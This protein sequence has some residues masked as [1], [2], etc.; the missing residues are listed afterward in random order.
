MSTIMTPNPT[1]VST[2]DSAIGALTIMV[3]N[4]FRHLPVVDGE[5]A[6]VGLLDIGKCL[7]DAIGR[8]ERA[9]K[10][11]GDSSSMD[12][13][14]QVAALRIPGN[15][16]AAVALQSLL[17][18]LM[19]QAAGGQAAVPTLRKLLRGKPSTIVW[20]STTI[21]ETARLMAESRHAAL[22]VDEGGSLV[23]IFGFK[24]M[25]TRVIACE[26][27]PD[28]TEVAEVMTSD[29]EFVSPDITVLEALQTMYD[30]KFLTVSI[31]RY[32]LC[33][34]QQDYLSH[35]SFLMS[36]CLYVRQMVL[37]LALLMLL[38]SFTDVVS[39]QG[40]Y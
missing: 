36:S 6:V 35:F 2:T 34:R 20:P 5:G 11:K 7:N 10:K 1:C 12:A 27:P 39:Y 32:F 13:V 26:L 21:R 25:M 29:P 17:G 3:E 30:N 16:N 37:L 14:N 38:N 4:H 31:D 22:V 19:S 18:T 28:E 40:L 23:G 15:P 24:D 9:E 8:L 33:P